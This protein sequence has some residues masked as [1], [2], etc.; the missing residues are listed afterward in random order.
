MVPP[1]ANGTTMRTGL[2]GQAPACAKAGAAKAPRQRA[3]AAARRLILMTGRLRLGGPRG[4]RPVRSVGEIGRR[5]L[6]AGSEGVG[7]VARACH[8][9]K[10]QALQR[11]QRC[12]FAGCRL[13]RLAAPQPSQDRLRARYES[14]E[15]TLRAIRRGRPEARAAKAKRDKDRGAGQGSRGSL[16]KPPRLA[17][18]PVVAGRRNGRRSDSSACTRRETVVGHVARVTRLRPDDL[19]AAAAPG[20]AQHNGTVGHECLPRPTRRWLSRAHARAAA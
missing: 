5:L 12:A 11:R 4:A 19:T 2:L 3:S 13:D 20:G 1:A 17:R 10:S 15:R 9:G 18:S 8:R 16:S 7:R 6:R 14:Q